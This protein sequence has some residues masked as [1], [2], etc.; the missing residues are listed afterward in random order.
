MNG[1]TDEEAKEILKGKTLKIYR[2][3]VKAKKPVGIR[4]TQKA[5]KL[6]SPSIAA[7][8]FSKLEEAGLIKREQGDYVVSKLVLTHSI[9]ISQFIVPRQLFYSIFA[10]CVL[11]L[12]LSIFRPIIINREYFFT[13][14]TTLVFMTFFFYET[15]NVWRKGEL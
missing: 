5:L 3:L 1:L 9:R 6:S 11:L 14:I 2:F 4:E 12:E 7:Y 13:I 8:H 10:I 15:I